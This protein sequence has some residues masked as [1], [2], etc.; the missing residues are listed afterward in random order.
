MNIHAQSTPDELLRV[1][2]MH[3]GQ[4]IPPTFSA[5]EMQRRHDGLRRSLEDPK[6]DAAPHE[7]SDIARL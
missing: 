6:L 4:K 3:N 5:A 7:Q 1:Q 2:T